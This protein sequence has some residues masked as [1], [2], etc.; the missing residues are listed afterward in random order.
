V[1]ASSGLAPL[2]GPAAHLRVDTL[3]TSST[4]TI[5]LAEE[6]VDADGR[7]PCAPTGSPPS[8]APGDTSAV[9]FQVEP[10]RV[11]GSD[12]TEGDARATVIDVLV[13]LNADLDETSL[14]GVTLAGAGGAVPVTASVDVDD[15]SIIVV[16]PETKF[17]PVG[18]YTLTLPGGA[19]GVAD[20]LGGELP[21]SWSLTFTVTE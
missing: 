6:V 10:L 12:P 15:P 9:S 17:L 20:A 11:L 8:C 2:L 4:C 19:G 14:G 16:V 5:A 1:V 21:E 18:S 13:Q 3:R 7:R